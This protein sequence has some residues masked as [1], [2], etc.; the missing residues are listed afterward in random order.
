MDLARLVR[1][2]WH[3]LQNLPD[4]ATLRFT[5]HAADNLP[6]PQAASGHLRV[7]L[8]NLLANAILYTPPGGTITVDL[9]PL[10][11]DPPP[12]L[13]LAITDTGQGIAPADLPRVRDRFYRADKAHTRAVKGAGLGLSIVQSIV[14]FYGATCTLSSP[15]IGLGATVTVTWPLATAP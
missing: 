7:L 11:G 8:R 13:R 2:V 5:L 14:D 3:D 4:A 12:A 10:P 6:H 1:A 9:M 15:G